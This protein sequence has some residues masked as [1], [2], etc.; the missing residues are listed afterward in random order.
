[1]LVLAAL[2]LATGANATAEQPGHFGAEAGLLLGSR[3]HSGYRNTTQRN[4][5]VPASESG[6]AG[7]WNDAAGDA[8]KSP[9]VSKI[10]ITVDDNSAI[11]LTITFANRQTLSGDDAV[12][13]FLDTDVEREKPD[14]TGQGGVDWL[15]LA[16]EAGWGIARSNGGSYDL[17]EV[18]PEASATLSAGVLTFNLHL[19]DI[20]SPTILGFRV[21]TSGSPDGRIE[22]T[23]PDSIL[24]SDALT[25]FETHADS[26]G[27]TQTATLDA[28]VHVGAARA[29]KLFTVLLFYNRSDSASPTTPR[30]SGKTITCEAKIA[31]KGLEAVTET[32]LGLVVRCGWRLPKSSRGKTIKG[33]VGV[34]FSSQ[35]WAVANRDFAQKI[36]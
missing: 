11:T 23:A 20:D 4:Q 24:G 25:V 31:G 10:E 29:G 30:L 15:L 16:D 22:E 26:S 6:T 12:N 34:V 1:M 17:V 33:S 5:L 2:A 19:K 7:S 13:V 28:S 14:V 8:G 18:P 9:D 35:R 27:S 36:R 32:S 21:A 3:A